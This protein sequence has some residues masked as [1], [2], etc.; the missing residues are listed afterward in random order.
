MRMTCVVAAAV[1]G[2]RVRSRRNWM[3]VV[4]VVKKLEQACQTP[5]SRLRQVV[6]AM[7]VEMHAGMASEGGSKLKM[8]LTYGIGIPKEEQDKVVKFDFH[9]QPEELKHGSVVIAA[10]TSCTNTSNP[11][12]M[13]GAGLIAKKAYELGLEVS[14]S[15]IILLSL[16]IMLRL[17]KFFAVLISSVS[18]SVICP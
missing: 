13:L 9:G 6:D 14:M 18:I 17:M 10:I 1:V 16:I 12:V 7:A 15:I 8:L 11:N 3:K 4:G 2:K 5:L